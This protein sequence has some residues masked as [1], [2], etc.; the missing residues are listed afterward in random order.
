MQSNQPFKTIQKGN[1][2]KEFYEVSFS[3]KEAS[4]KL[5]RDKA[6]K[7]FLEE[8]KGYWE[9][10]IQHISSYCYCVETTSDGCKVYLLRPTFLNKGIDFQVWISGKSLSKDNFR[11]S[12]KDIFNDLRV[13]HKESHKQFHLLLEA[14]DKV[15]NCED[16]DEVLKGLN[17]K[18]GFSAELL[19]KILKWLFIEQD[20]TYWNYDGR[21][22]LKNGIDKEFRNT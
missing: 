2:I 21:A 8:K 4:R 9:D 12:H 3:L 6:V 11:P 16:P 1:K 10:G 15:W 19:L 20:I 7:K 14:I 5:L 13:K 22:M 17:F 18:E